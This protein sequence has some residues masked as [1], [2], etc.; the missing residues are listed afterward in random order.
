MSARLREKRAAPGARRELI[1][2]RRGMMFMV[3]A[4][5]AFAGE[6]E[7]ATRVPVAS[8]DRP[9]IKSIAGACC[10]NPVARIEYVS[11]DAGRTYAL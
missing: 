8:V 7:T 11:G 5:R 6:V 2:G 9:R 3:D 1:S 4:I 10:M